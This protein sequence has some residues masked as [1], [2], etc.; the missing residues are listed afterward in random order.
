MGSLSAIPGYDALKAQA[1]TAKAQAD[2]YI[3]QRNV[4]NS[5]GNTALANQYNTQAAEA[6]ASYINLNTQLQEL[7][8]NSEN[9]DLASPTAKSSAGVGANKDDNTKP[10]SSSAQSAINVSTANLN[11][12]IPTQPNQLDQYASYTYSIGWYLLTTEQFNAM[13]ETQRPNVTG[14]QLLMQSGGA[15]TKGRSPAFPLDYYMDDLEIT[16]KCVGGGTRQAHSAVDIR[17]KVTEPNGITLIESI[18]KAVQ[19]L[20]KTATQPQTQTSN[21]GAAAAKSPEAK[22]KPSYLQALYCLVIEFYGYDKDGKL[23]APAKGTFSTNAQTGGYGQ[24][25]VISKYYPFRLKEIKFQIAN[26]AIEYAIS[27]APQGQSYAFSTDRGTIPNSFTMS[28]STVEQLLNGPVV[29]SGAGATTSKADPGARK[30]TFAQ[31]ATITG[32]A[33]QDV[34]GGTINSLGVGA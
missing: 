24:T 29:S 21:N 10:T 27:A 32:E 16:T 13:G 5:S 18:F 33:N 3:E 4:A 30:D 28:G 19:S 34:G 26:R 20:N 14:W 23:V 6:T 12:L 22:G 25:A 1:A 11:K 15:P 8:L 9:T 7:I 31:P 2:T 17:F